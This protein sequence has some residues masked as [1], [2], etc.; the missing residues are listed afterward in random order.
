MSGEQRPDSY[1]PMALRADVDASLDAADELRTHPRGT[2]GLSAKLVYLNDEQGVP[3]G[4]KIENILRPELFGVL[5]ARLL[6][7]TD[8]PATEDT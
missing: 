8:R 2:G 6:S 4:R 5:P 3:R 1:D 7:D